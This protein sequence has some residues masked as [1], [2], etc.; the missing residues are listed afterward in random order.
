LIE[1]REFITIGEQYS[2]HQLKLN[3][4]KE[5]YLTKHDLKHLQPRL[6]GA[7]SAVMDG[8]RL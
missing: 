6:S 4:C 1:S 7:V 3:G 5:F 8:M 2:E